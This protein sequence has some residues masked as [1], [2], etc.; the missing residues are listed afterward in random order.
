MLKRM[1]LSTS[2]RPV[3]VIKFWHN[4]GMLLLSPP[5]QRGDVWGTRRR[6]NLMRSLL[7]GVPIPS[8]VVNDRMNGGWPSDQ[9]DMAVIDGKQRCTSFLM[10]LNDEL[11]IP[12]EWVGVDASQC[13]YSE[14]PKAMQRHIAN[15]PVAFSEGTLRTIEGEKE[16][17]DLINFGGVPQGES[18]NE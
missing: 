9:W 6:V 4:E 5:Y 18:D 2:N 3:E 13:V 17:F 8:I 14:L 16:V 7:L 11:P 1:P 15:R 12:G 10:F